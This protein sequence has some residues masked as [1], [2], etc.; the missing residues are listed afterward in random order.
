MSI[1]RSDVE[2][3]VREVLMAQIGGAAAPSTKPNPLVVNISPV[4]LT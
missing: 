2:R 1:A 4:M 3:I